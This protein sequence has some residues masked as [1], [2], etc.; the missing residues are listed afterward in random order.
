MTTLTL[1][2]IISLA[3]VGEDQTRRPC[4]HEET[5]LV[6]VAVRIRRRPPSNR[7]I[8]Q[9]AHHSADHYNSAPVTTSFG[10]K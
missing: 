10:P 7:S 9:S 6:G 4:F 5:W 8:R 2:I 1:R 3:D